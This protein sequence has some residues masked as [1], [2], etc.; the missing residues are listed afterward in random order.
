M[1]H[2]LERI[3][4]G[5]VKYLCNDMYFQMH[6][7]IIVLPPKASL[8]DIV[9]WCL[10]TGLLLNLEKLLLLCVITSSLCC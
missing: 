10:A 8:L 1:P 2:D 3:S 4:Q 5:S 7:H 6:G 9:M